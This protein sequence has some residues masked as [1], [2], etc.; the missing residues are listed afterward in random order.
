MITISLNFEICFLEFLCE[1]VFGVISDNYLC[2]KLL[3]NAI[4]TLIYLTLFWYI[5]SSFYYR[6]SSK[7]L[8]P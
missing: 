3:E 8:L 2:L 7:N 6:I 4:R 5:K 1:I